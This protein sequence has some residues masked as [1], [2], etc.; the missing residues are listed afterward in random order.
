[1]ARCWSATMPCSGAWR[2][3]IRPCA[4]RTGRPR[5]SGRALPCPVRI[6]SLLPPYPRSGIAPPLA[7]QKSLSRQSWLAEEL[8]EPAEVG[9]GI[10]AEPRPQHAG[11]PTAL[12]AGA[13]LAPARPIGAGQIA[14]VPAAQPGG[15]DGEEP[16]RAAQHR[17]RAVGLAAGRPPLVAAVRPEQLLEV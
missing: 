10:A 3:S 6:G 8:F 13:H 2:S 1:M 15:Q 9:S 11:V 5:E 12:E 7:G 14:G 4:S 16:H 17:R